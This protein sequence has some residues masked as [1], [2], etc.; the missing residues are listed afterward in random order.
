MGDALKSGQSAIGSLDEAKR[1]LDRS[2]WRNALARLQGDGVEEARRTLGS[3]AA[4]VEEKLRQMRQRR[5]QRARGELRQAGEDEEKLADR[6]RNLEEQARDTGS[7]PDEALGALGAAERAAH[8]AANALVQ[9]EGERGLE[10]QREAQ[11]QLEAARRDVQGSEDNRGG[12]GGNGEEFEDQR[13]GIP[14]GHKG[15]EEFRQRVLKGIAQPA[16]GPVRD[17]WRRYAEGLLR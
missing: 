5:E 16:A 10:R 11:R 15:P 4:W 6:A 7:L 14:S 8:E 3:E 9:G 12:E 17:A 1:M 13:V 2:G